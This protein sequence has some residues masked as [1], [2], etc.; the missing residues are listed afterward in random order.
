VVVGLTVLAQPLQK[1]PQPVYRGAAPTQ[2][3]MQGQPYRPTSFGN[4]GGCPNGSCP[5]GT[6]PTVRLGA[7]QFGTVSP[8]Q[9]NSPIPGPGYPQ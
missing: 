7:P 9:L 4:R 8:A 3:D 5:T 6:P 1:T 2:E